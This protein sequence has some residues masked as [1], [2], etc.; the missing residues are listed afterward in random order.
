MDT[1]QVPGEY[2]STVGKTSNEPRGIA[3]EKERDTCI[4]V[5]LV[6][7]SQGRVAGLDG[8]YL[9]VSTMKEVFV[10]RGKEAVKL[11]RHS[12]RPKTGKTYQD[13]LSGKA[14][15]AY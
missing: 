1:E 13:A 11:T 3:R 15:I 14:A 10:A 8:V 9:R 5:S 7:A 2:Q 12:I 4:S 6:Y